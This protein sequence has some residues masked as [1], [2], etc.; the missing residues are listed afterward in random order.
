M[1]VHFTWK[2]PAVAICGRPTAGGP[3]V[4]LD[5]ISDQ[6]ARIRERLDAVK[7]GKGSLWRLCALCEDAKHR[8]QFCEH[9]HA[10][11]W[12]DDFVDGSACQCATLFLERRPEDGII[13]VQ[14]IEEFNA[15]VRR[16]EEETGHGKRTR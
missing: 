10:W 1:I 13:V 6:P 5:G 4:A 2:H 12:G 11:Q 7:R 16:R 3:Y 8:G 15:S 14:T 9:G